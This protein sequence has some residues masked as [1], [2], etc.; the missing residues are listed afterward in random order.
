MIRDSVARAIE[1]WIEDRGN[2]LPDRFARLEQQRLARLLEE[3][4]E[5]EKRREPFEVLPREEEQYVE[6]SG[7]RAKV[8]ID[9]I[10]RPPDGR[11]IIID[12]KTGHPT[13]HDW[14]GSRPNEPQV[15]L[16]AVTRNHGSRI[17]GVLF[18]QIRPGE[19]RFRG[20]VDDTVVL[21]SADSADLAE[22]VANWE[23]V[24]NSL[25]EQ[26]LAG[27]AE[28][29]PNDPAKACRYCALTLLCRC[30]ERQQIEVEEA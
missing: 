11:E 23:E 20:L 21:P 10:D 25:G 28:A 9:R 13:V 22:Q 29:D 2:L 17:A 14:E 19:M 4:L 15:P 12:Y 16:Y 8:K 24:L 18:G 26:F 30:G 27:R 6:A 7:I 1:R 3:W 5:Y